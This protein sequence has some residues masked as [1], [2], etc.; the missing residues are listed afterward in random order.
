VRSHATQDL[1]RPL[2]SYWQLPMYDLDFRE[3][4]VPLEDLEA[5]RKAALWAE[6]GHHPDRY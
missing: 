1:T 3:L 5:E 2:W 4:Q 6:I